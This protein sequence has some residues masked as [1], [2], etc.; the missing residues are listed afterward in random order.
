MVPDTRCEL[1]MTML[2]NNLKLANDN[3][4]GLAVTEENRRSFKEFWQRHKDSPMADRNQILRAL[5]PQLCGLFLAKLSV[6]L[7]LIGEVAQTGHGTRVR[8]EG[9]LLMIGDPG[10]GKPQL[11]KFARSV[12][13]SRID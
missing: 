1:E 12:V 4:A 3:K 13:C 6:L 8:G 5:C 2:A 9:Q 7:T 11:L 10:T